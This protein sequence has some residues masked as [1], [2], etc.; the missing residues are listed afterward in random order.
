MEGRDAQSSGS[1][2][3]VLIMKPSHTFA[4]VAPVGHQKK[5]H[6]RGYVSNRW[7]ETWACDSE[8]IAKLV[9]K[10][11]RKGQSPGWAGRDV[12]LG[13]TK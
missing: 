9:M 6:V 2:L 10:R 11:L 1:E 3:K 13:R 12:R 7:V 4:I 5:W 8:A